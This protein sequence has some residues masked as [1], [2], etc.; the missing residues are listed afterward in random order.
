[1]S[2]KVTK[3]RINGVEKEIGG[4]GSGGISGAYLAPKRL[5]SPEYT[6][7]NQAAINPIALVEQLEKAGVAVDTPVMNPN[8]SSVDLRIGYVCPD[9]GDKNPIISLNIARASTGFGIAFTAMGSNTIQVTL[10]QSTLRSIINYLFTV[11][12]TDFHF[13]LEE[14]YAGYLENFINIHYHSADETLHYYISNMTEFC[15]EVIIKY[16]SS[17]DSSN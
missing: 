3:I 2:D 7:F 4:S 14:E 9:S 17:S 6:G 5:V 15:E 12:L 10:S 1:M 8:E 16:N 13:T 11:M